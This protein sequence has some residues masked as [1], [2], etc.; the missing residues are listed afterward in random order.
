MKLLYKWFLLD[1][2]TWKG[3]FQHFNRRGTF[4]T[5]GDSFRKFYIC[6]NKNKSNNSFRIVNDLME[7]FYQKN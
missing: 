3:F 6:I 1:I 4:K 7:I 2:M 5:D